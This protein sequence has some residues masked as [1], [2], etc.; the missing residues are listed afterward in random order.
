MTWWHKL[1]LGTVPVT[2]VFV[3]ILLFQVSAFVDRSNKDE[4]RIASSVQLALDTVNAE[5]G[6]T[7]HCGTLAELDKILV[8]TS[9]LEVQTQMLVRHGDRLTQTES[10][11]LP[12]WNRRI[13]GTLNGVDRA[14]GDFNGNQNKIT[15]AVLPILQDTDQTIKH[16]DNLVSSSY[17]V[18][19]LKNIDVSTAS[20]AETTKQVSATVTDIREETDRLTHPPAKK[21]GFWGG[22]WAGAQV[23]HK[24]SPPLF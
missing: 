1:A 4:G 14:V 8:H 24:L 2:G 20:V 23:I 18:E 13:T 9:D 16:A 15:A 19:S 10:A 6:V 11:M 7:V 21:L 22:V 3:C 17:V 5:C 12:E